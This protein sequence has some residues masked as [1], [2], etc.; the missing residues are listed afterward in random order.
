M[1]QLVSL[2]LFDGAIGSHELN[3]WKRPFWTTTR[4]SYEPKL[5]I[6]LQRAFLL[7]T[8]VRVRFQ[9]HPKR[10]LL[11][12]SVDIGNHT[13]FSRNYAK[14]SIDWNGKWPNS[15]IL[16]KRCGSSAV[17]RTSDLSTAKVGTSYSETLLRNCDCSE[18]MQQYSPMIP[19]FSNP[20]AFVTYNE[21]IGS[22]YGIKASPAHL[23]STT[24]MFAWGMDLYYHRLAPSNAFD[25]LPMEFNHSML[26]LL[27]IGFILATLASRHFARRKAL[28]QAWK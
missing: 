1:T 11:S 19:M 7:P 24:L 14:V 17:G 5:P 28:F 10:Q 8:R 6:V 26:V 21:T 13:H 25:L 12:V 22:I 20:T 15:Q 18:G 23:E 3:L 2:F 16:K 27:C 4:S 9:L